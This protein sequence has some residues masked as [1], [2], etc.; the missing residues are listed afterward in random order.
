MQHLRASLYGRGAK[1]V[2]PRARSSKTMCFQML[3]EMSPLSVIIAYLCCSD[4]KQVFFFKLN[5]LTLNRNQP[6]MSAPDAI[7]MLTV[8]GEVFFFCFSPIK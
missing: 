1:K 4:S 8:L 2:S 5:V 6:A 7:I 3:H